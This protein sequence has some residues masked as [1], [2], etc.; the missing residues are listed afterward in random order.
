MLTSR[1]GNG[2]SS[3]AASGSIGI[4]FAGD[5]NSWLA[6]AFMAGIANGQVQIF[7]SAGQPV[8]ARP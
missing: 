7:D 4:R 1:M 5:T 3:G 8:T 6:Q 2:A